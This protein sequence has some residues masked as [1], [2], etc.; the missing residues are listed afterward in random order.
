[1]SIRGPFHCS[2]STIRDSFHVLNEEI[3][4]L[5]SFLIIKVIYVYYK[6]LEKQEKIELIYN[7]IFLR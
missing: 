4:S 3:L 1:M 6:I 7:P 5:L 2:C